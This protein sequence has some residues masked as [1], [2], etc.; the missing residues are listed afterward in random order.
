MKVLWLDNI[1]LNANYKAAGRI[2]WTEQNNAS[3]ALL[4]YALNGRVSLNK[5]NGQIAFWV[6]NALNKDYQAYFEP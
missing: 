4:R 6:N 5:G 3:Q 2:Y 1:T